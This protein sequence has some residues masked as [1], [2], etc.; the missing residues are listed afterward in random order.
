MLNFI[1]KSCKTWI[2]SST[3][4]AQSCFK[5][6]PLWMYENYENQILDSTYICVSEWS[7]KGF[8]TLQMLTLNSNLFQNHQEGSPPQRKLNSIE[9]WFSQEVKLNTASTP[10]A[11]PKEPK[12][13]MTQI[14]QALL[15]YKDFSAFFLFMQ[16]IDSLHSGWAI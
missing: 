2:T 7:F 16:S 14:Y 15:H 10:T 8:T 6:F 12:F 4:T 1:K 5:Y 11:L 13:K 3:L 9:K